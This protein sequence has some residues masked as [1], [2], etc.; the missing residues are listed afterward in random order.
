M[1]GKPRH[2]PVLAFTRMLRRRAHPS[3]A[4]SS[5]HGAKAV[6]IPPG[7]PSHRDERQDHHDYL[8]HAH[9][10]NGGK[11]RRCRRQYGTT[12]IESVASDAANVYVAKVSSFQ[13]ASMDLF[14]PQVAVLLNITPDHLY[15]H[16]TFDAYAEA[17]ERLPPSG[18]YARHLG[19]RCG[20]RCHARLRQR[21]R[22]ENRTGFFLHTPRLRRRSG[23]QHD[24]RMQVRMRHGSVR[25]HAACRLQ[26]R[27]R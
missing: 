18:R 4:R 21:I 27:I 19:Y 16:M 1:R 10:G 14:A 26:R 3:S 23:L 22:R 6:L 8:D 15:W 7:S 13:L 9:S 11:A 24:R 17:Q 5:S 2:I 20:V 25:R 12:C